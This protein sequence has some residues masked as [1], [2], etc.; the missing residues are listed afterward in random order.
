MWSNSSATV[1]EMFN[2]PIMAGKE[3]NKP[4]GKN[5]WN[6]M[7][8]F[9]SNLSVTFYLF[10]KKKNISQFRRT[11]SVRTSCL[12]KGGSKEGCFLVCHTVF[13]EPVAVNF[14]PI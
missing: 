14:T 2:Q 10:K 11:P 4:N 8:H 7:I 6:T 13:K 5:N 1:T 12:E 3:E 9:Q